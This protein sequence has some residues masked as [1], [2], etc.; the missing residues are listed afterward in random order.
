MKK[1]RIVME[2]YEFTIIASAV[3]RQHDE[4]AGALFDA[5][6]SDATVSLQKGLTI[7]EFDREA[8]TFFHALRSALDDVARTGL[9]VLHIEPD[10]LVSITD[11]AVR[12]KITKAAVSNYAKGTRGK[13]FP[14]PVAR[15]TTES[16]LW[17]WVDVARWLFRQGKLP[18]PELVRARV[19]RRENGEI[20]RGRFSRAG[21]AHH[22]QR[23]A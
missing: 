18:L 7:L 6:C 12:A 17:D 5:G 16:P 3:D 2:T 23:A 11:I 10:H 19:V 14:V 15:V 9:E 20:Q 4:L 1:W 21:N 22:P 13:N 8:K